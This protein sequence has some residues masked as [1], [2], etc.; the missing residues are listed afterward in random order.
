MPLKSKNILKAQNDCLTSN[1]YCPIS[2]NSLEDENV[3]SQLTHQGKINDT[4]NQSQL[5]KF[6]NKKTKVELSKSF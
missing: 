5:Y 4:F 6:E 2:I 1:G 3:K